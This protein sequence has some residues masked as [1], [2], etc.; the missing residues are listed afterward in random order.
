VNWLSILI[1]GS[2]CFLTI[3]AIGASLPEGN[4]GLAAHYPNEKGLAADQ[5]VLFAED[6]SGTNLSSL[7]KRWESVNDPTNLS[8]SAES[9]DELIAKQSLLITHESG[10]GTGSHLYRRLPS[11]LTQVFA[12][13]YV[14]FD[15]SCWPIHH[16]GTHLGGFCPSTPWPQ[17]GAGHRPDG[18]KRFTSGV[19]PFG[20]RWEWDFYSYWQG[21]RRHGDGAYWGTPFLQG[22]P[23]QKI[24]KNKWICVEMMIKLND[25]PESKNGEQAFWIDGKLVRHEGQII[26]HIGPGFPKGNWKGGWWSPK[27]TSQQSFEGF[28]WRSIP[29]LDI[30]YLWTYLYITKAPKGHISRVWFDQIVVATEYIGP[31]QS[32]DP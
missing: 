14:R 18:A 30:N 4:N 8:L 27:S 22:A 28:E 24:P 10:K 7:L 23:K 19:E 13:W 21:M 11:G 1:L 29:E 6:F 9:P 3:Q 15:P 5:A 31:I 16:F 26:S 25:P 20:E 17:G 2:A 12:R 32:S